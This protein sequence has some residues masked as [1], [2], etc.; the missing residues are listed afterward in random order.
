MNRWIA[1]QALLISIVVLAGASSAAAQGLPGRDYTA[2]DPPRGTS[3]PDRIVVT[4]FF[5]YQCPHCYAFHPALK[6]WARALPDDVVLERQA[7]SIGRPQWEPAARAF[8]ALG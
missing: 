3:D 4:E 2:L 1:A 7:V 5:S 6:A 8:Y